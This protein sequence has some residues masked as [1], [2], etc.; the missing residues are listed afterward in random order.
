[1]PLIIRPLGVDA[2]MAGLFT[3]TAGA[4]GTL[5]TIMAANFNLVPVALLKMQNPLGVIRFQLPYAAVMWGCHVLLL[6]A[7]IRFA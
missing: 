1:M 7:L 2:S 4:C 6:W 3:L 5:V